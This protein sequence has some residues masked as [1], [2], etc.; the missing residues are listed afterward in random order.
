MPLNQSAEENLRI[1]RSLMERTATYRSIS[2]PSA[3]WAGVVSVAAFLLNLLLIQTGNL[4]FSFSGFLLLWLGVLV[5]AAIGNTVILYR[6]AR[7]AGTTFPSPAMLSAI[8]GMAPAFLAAG[9]LTGI[10]VFL[11]FTHTYNFM[12]SYIEVP[13]W[14]LFYGIGLLG[15][16]HFAPRSIILLGWAFLLS[17]LVVL[18]ATPFAFFTFWGMKNQGNPTYYFPSAI[19][20]ATFGGYHLLYAALVARSI[21]HHQALNVAQP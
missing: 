16:Q 8:S 13:L 15:T 1:I 3:T 4:F 7:R 6:E 17:A 2:V 12:F 11:D 18:I 10:M 14:M 19:M 21:R 9:V 20:A 5:L